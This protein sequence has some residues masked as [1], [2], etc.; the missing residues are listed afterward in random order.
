M[1]LNRTEQ[2][3]KEELKKRIARRK[4]ELKKKMARKK[5]EEDYESEQKEV[6]MV[7]QPLVCCFLARA[8]SA[9]AY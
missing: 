5:E 2:E 6:M 3:W 9:T 7:S 4:A 8:L 1:C